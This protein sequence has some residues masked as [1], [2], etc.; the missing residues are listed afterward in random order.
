[1]L[2]DLLAAAGDAPVIDWTAIREWA[3]VGGGLALF[4][5]LF[6]DVRGQN[7]SSASDILANAQLAQGTFGT[8]V[9]ERLQRVEERLAAVEDERDAE[10]EARYQ[11]R[12]EY[13]TYREGAR[14]HVTHLTH[15]IWTG[16]E[17]GTQAA[18]LPPGFTL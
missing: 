14:Q 15:Q 13:F 9:A 7:K 18:P 2:H 4:F 8:S 6:T 1:M 11:L 17:P 3:L 12:E 5:K 10:R 16:T